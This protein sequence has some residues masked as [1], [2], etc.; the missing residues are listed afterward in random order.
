MIDKV[1]ALL[2]KT[3]DAG[4]TKE[5]ADA[6]MKAAARLMQKYN[7]D[8]V[9]VENKEADAEAKRLNLVKEYV[10]TGRD[11]CYTD[12]HIMH[13]LRQCFCL[14]VYYSWGYDWDA[15]ED[16][17]KKYNAAYQERSTL[18][19]EAFW[20]FK[21]PK[22][23][24]LKK[25]FVYVLVGDKPDVELGA[26]MIP[27]F[28]R[29]MRHGLAKHCR[30]ENIPWAAVAAE[31]FHSGFAAGYIDVNEEAMKEVLLEAPEAWAGKYALAVVDKEKAV[32]EFAKQSVTTVRAR[33]GSGNGA[34][35]YGYDEKAAQKGRKAGSSINLKSGRIGK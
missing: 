33:A 19:G 31:S 30:E 5:E 26:Q 22:R 23:P 4:C 16:A 15:E 14:R 32:E 29:I 13:I 24:S 2:R 3:E 21:M 7:I 35:S 27:E 17:R 11:K 34:R 12:E 25:R 1:R 8:Q 9:M 6:A 18:T 10:K 20:A 28:R